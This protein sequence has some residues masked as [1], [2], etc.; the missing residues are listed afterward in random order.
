MNLISLDG[1]GI[2]GLIQA[3]VLSYLENIGDFND[4]VSHYAGTSIGG[5]NVLYLALSNKNTASDLL[6]IFISSYEQ[7]FSGKNHFS[8]IY[9]PRYSSEG[10]RNVVYRIFGEKKLSDLETDCTIVSYDVFSQEPFYF[11]SHKAKKD[12]K[13]D[14]KLV[15]VALATS[16]APTY[17]NPHYCKDQSGKNEYMFID[18]AVAANNPT[19][20]GI[21]TMRK[22]N[23]ELTVT[24]INTL[25][26]G[27]IEN[28]KSP[29][30]NAILKYGSARWIKLVIDILMS[31]SSDV[32]HHN[33]KHSYLLGGGK[34]YYRIDAGLTKSSSDLDDISKGN[35]S[36]LLNDAVKV[37]AEYDHI[38]RKFYFNLL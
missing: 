19:F 4:R 13:Y 33:V 6:N 37:S 5:I 26:I 10:I 32:I 35:I 17:F 3:Y 28:M 1:D 16:A 30:Y 29:S 23:P 12:P 11:E 25:S 7:I 36:N 9:G 14:F 22:K 27:C 31:A 38:L 18:G 15:D 34:N 8:F 21:I 2:K 24:N 20:S